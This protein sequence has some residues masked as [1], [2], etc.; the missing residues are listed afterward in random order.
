MQN[1]HFVNRAKLDW[2]DHNLSVLQFCKNQAD[3][4]ALAQSNTSEFPLL[5]TPHLPV[6]RGVLRWALLDAILAN[7]AGN[8]LFEGITAI[9]IDYQGTPILEL[10]GKYTSLTACH[11][12]SRDEKPKDSENGYRKNNRAKNQKNQELFKEFE[13]PVSEDDLLHI[14][15]LHGGRNDDF[16]YLRIYLED[17][18]I[19]ALTGNIMLMPSLE[20]APDTELVLKP[21]VTL[22]EKPIVPELENL[23]T[24][25]AD[26]TKDEH[27]HP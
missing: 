3:A 25:P 22:N 21:V 15:L 4:A 16:A 11:V 5:D 27:S 10:R 7:A 20:M 12:L 8:H 6:V 2:T 9:W 17:S 19:P 18:D 1:D 14:I 24:S 23:P 13:A 26:K